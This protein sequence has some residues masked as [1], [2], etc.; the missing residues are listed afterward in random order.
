M[1][2]QLAGDVAAVGDD[3]VDGDAEV[4]GDL[5]VRHTLHQGDDDILLTVGE[6]IGILTRR[7][8]E[9][10]VGDVAGDVALLGLLL[11][12]ADGGHEDMRRMAGTKI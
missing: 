11:Q 9:H 4:V 1:D 6:G 5:L 2:L 10:H 8:L 12:T 3:G 7:C